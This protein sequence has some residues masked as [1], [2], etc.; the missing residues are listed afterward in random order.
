MKILLVED[1]LVLSLI[2]TK[3][4]KANHY[5]IDH[6]NDGQVGLELATTVEYDLILLD[7]HDSGRHCPHRCRIASASFCR[8]S[9]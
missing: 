8:W 1:A 3:V 6:A 2:L 7:V 5:A 9:R 4:L